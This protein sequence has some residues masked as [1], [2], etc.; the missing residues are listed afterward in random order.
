MTLCHATSQMFPKH[1]AHLTLVILEALASIA[2]V[3]TVAAAQLVT[4]LLY[5]KRHILQW[6]LLSSIF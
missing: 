2:I 3:S 6:R 4:F 1:G 5:E